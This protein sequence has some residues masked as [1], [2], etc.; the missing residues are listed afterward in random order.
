[1]N[2]T[3]NVERL[4]CK[5][6]VDGLQDVVVSADWRVTG[7]KDGFV[8]TCYGQVTFAPAVASDFIPYQDLTLAKVVQ[9]VQELL[10][11]DQVAAI[12]SNV[13]QQIAE[14]VN[15]PIITPRLPWLPVPEEP[16]VVEEP[17]AQ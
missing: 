11:A 13:A 8:G 3:W 4:N 2:I 6:S 1:M 7:T 10:G 5:P 12:E 15:P 16:V 14:Q 9:W 17:V